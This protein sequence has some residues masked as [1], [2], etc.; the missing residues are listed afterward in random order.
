[1]VLPAALS[2]TEAANIAIKATDN[3]KSLLDAETKRLSSMGLRRSLAPA[4]LRTWAAS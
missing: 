1:V 2:V 3:S 4:L